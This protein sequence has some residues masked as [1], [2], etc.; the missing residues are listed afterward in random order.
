MSTLTLNIKEIQPMGPTIITGD[1]NSHITQLT[2]AQIKRG[3]SKYD[4]ALINLIKQT[5]L[6][7]LSANKKDIKENKHWTYHGYNNTHSVND[8]ILTHNTDNNP[9]YYTVHQD[10][11]CGSTHRLITARIDFQQENTTWT[12]GKP[13]SY[14]MKWDKPTTKKYQ[15]TIINIIHN[16]QKEMENI[17]TLTPPEQ[18]IN[19]AH[20]ITTT[21]QNAT[22]ICASHSPKHTN[23]TR[24]R[25]HNKRID[26]KIPY[27]PSSNRKSQP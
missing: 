11:N 21:I 7:P 18:I 17:H 1:F 15:D 2:N 27:P 12:W 10:I 8:Y 9:K 26:K 6:T 25:T 22:E 16:T 23:H 20:Y 5:H 13:E 19:L 3:P 14:Y 4:K 24:T